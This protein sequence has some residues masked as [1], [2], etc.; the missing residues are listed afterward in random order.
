[1]IYK[2]YGTTG[3]KVSAVGFGGMRFDTNK[4]N[5]ENAELLL[6][7]RQK[8]INYF[9]TAPS[10]CNDTSEDIFGIA[11]KQMASQR[12]EFHVSTKGMPTEFDT[13]DKARAVVEKSLKR[14]NTDRI[15]FYHV[16]CIR[17]MDHYD[18]AMK[19]GGQYEGLLKCKDQGL[20]KNITVSTHL[21][22]NEIAA[23][24]KDGNF[25]GVL[26]GVNILNFLYRWQGV[27][28]AYDGGY[29]VVAMNPL[30]GGLIPKFA[31]QLSFLAGEGE[32]P[33]EAAIRFC[34]SCPEITVALVGFTTKE[35]IDTACRVADNCSQFTQV[36]IDRIKENV[37]ENM[38]ALCTG[39][40]YCADLCPQNI[41][42]PNYM[43]FY[44]NK[45]LGSKTDKEMAEAIGFEHQ[46]G[47]LVGR[48]ASAGDCI[49]CGKCEE[50]CTQHLNIIER[51][52]E[53]AEWEK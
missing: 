14:L 20:I 34:T 4:S 36:D 32:T 46:W 7:A 6:Y 5:E 23:I 24:I 10:Y 27:K 48:K 30:S 25:K 35:H 28:A 41:P 43:Q 26:M 39:C 51:L 15:D 17:T 16:W 33:V 8:G 19:K 31:D 45:A 37:S 40:G 49:E 53:I 38:D 29:G 11:I 12:D 18:L 21:P 2:D 9:D 3:I 42:V 44:N 13:A 22:G 50:A 1:M 47:L 52:K